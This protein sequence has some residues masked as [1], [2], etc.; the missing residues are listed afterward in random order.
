[1]SLGQAILMV[2]A[3][4]A[5]GLAL[6]RG[7]PTAQ[8]ALRE[9]GQTILRVLPLLVAA[10][11]MAAFL[12]KLIPADLAAGWLGP[13]SGLAGIAI[14]SLAGGFIPGGPFVS[15]PLVLTFI[16]AGAGGP[17]MVALI[18]GWAILGFHRVIAWEW[19]VLGGRFILIRLLA[20]GL[21][22]ILAGVLAQWLLPL[23][24]HAL[25]RP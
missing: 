3:L 21:L 14:A 23:F 17:Q 15:F 2:L 5:F 24:P 6:R 20:S 13:E 7:V 18:T 25:V 11:P 4:G 22:P 16:K 19:P 10:L 12:A 1:M 9:T 8:R